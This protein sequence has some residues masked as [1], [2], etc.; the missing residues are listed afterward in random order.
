M[1]QGTQPTQFV[2]FA[3]NDASLVFLSLVNDAGGGGNAAAAA[4]FLER[5]SLGGYEF[6]RAWGGGGERNRG[7]QARGG[8]GPGCA[9]SGDPLAFGGR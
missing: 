2:F 3:R 4:A 7:R 5:R 9:G 8:G 6:D 1:L